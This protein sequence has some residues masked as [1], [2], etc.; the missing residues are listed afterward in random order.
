MMAQINRRNDKFTTKVLWLLLGRALYRDYI[1][2]YPNFQSGAETACH[3]ALPLRTSPKVHILHTYDET[4]RQPPPRIRDYIPSYTVKFVKSSKVCILYIGTST[5]VTCGRIAS[6]WENIFLRI[7]CNY[8][9]FV[10]MRTPINWR[11]TGALP[12]CFAV[13]LA[14]H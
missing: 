12:T 1:K 6:L 11:P 5:H 2:R 13:R 14:C 10:A 4:V 7:I 8:I 3:S 9:S